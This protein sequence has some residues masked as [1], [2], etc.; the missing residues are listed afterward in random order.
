M[1]R[2]FTFTRSMPLRCPLNDLL[3]VRTLAQIVMPV[4]DGLL[5]EPFQ[6]DWIDGAVWVGFERLHDV[7]TPGR[8]ENGAGLV[9]LHR[10]G[11]IFDFGQQQ[12]PAWEPAEIAA[13][14]LRSAIY[15]IFLRQRREILAVVQ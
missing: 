5:L 1:G 3:D 14:I 2:T 11:G 13:R 9:G 8:L 6:R 12:A 7:I 10:E 15:R 4:I